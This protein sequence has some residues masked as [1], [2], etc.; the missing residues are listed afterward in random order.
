MIRFYLDIYHLE[1][2]LGSAVGVSLLGMTTGIDTLI[3]WDMGPLGPYCEIH[4][5][6]LL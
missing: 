5:S 3:S 1:L 2:L 6:R 4:P